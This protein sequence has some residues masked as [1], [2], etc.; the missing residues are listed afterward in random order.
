[1]VYSRF[2]QFD[3]NKRAKNARKY[4]GLGP[5]SVMMSVVCEDYF[6]IFFIIRLRSLGL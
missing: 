2:Q 3:I 1:M 4:W 6:N 5:F